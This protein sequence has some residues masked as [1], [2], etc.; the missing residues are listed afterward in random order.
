MLDFDEAAVERQTEVKFEGKT[1][2]LKEPTEEAVV[3]YRGHGLKN[4]KYVDGKL[5]ADVGSVYEAQALLVSLCLF[6]GANPVGLPFV[7]SMPTSVVKAVFAEAKRMGKLDEPDT[8]ETLEKRI[9]DDQEK[10]AKLRD[11]GPKG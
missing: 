10:L 4:S 9:A 8:E 2:T 11:R 7:R 6:D 5:Q 1:Y 3:K